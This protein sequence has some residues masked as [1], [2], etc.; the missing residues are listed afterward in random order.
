MQSAGIPVAALLVAGRPYPETGIGVLL[1]MVREN[2]HRLASGRFLG[3]NNSIKV[4]DMWKDE[5]RILT[6][7]PAFEDEPLEVS[8]EHEIIQEE[9]RLSASRYTY[10][11]W[12]RGSRV[13]TQ[14]YIAFAIANLDAVTVL[15]GA[16]MNAVLQKLVEW[17]W[18]GSLRTVR[19]M[20]AETKRHL[21]SFRQA[22]GN[23]QVY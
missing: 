22:D 11:L 15:V 2:G 9:C 7:A 1:L 16:S 19:L 13:S 12:I 4:S 3:K 5:L 20:G 23:H 17:L 10:N 6:L 21:R 18:K 8:L 14:V